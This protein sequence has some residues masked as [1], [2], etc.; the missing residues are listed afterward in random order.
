MERKLNAVPK[1]SG[2][3]LVS[4]VRRSI[5]QLPTNEKPAEKLMPHSSYLIAYLYSQFKKLSASVEGSFDRIYK[6]TGTCSSLGHQP[7]KIQILTLLGGGSDSKV[8][9]LNI[10]GMGNIGRLPQ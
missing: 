10:R 9:Y 7:F 2:A 5:S 4:S 6:I 1:A 3:A 8:S